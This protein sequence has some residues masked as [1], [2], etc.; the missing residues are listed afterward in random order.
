MNNLDANK[1]ILLTGA[2]GLVGSYLLKTLLNRNHRVYVIAR[3]KGNLS[4]SD[5][6]LNSLKFWGGLSEKTILEKIVIIEGD[7]TK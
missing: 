4:A 5:R 7:I 2:T 6:V 3:K 1:K